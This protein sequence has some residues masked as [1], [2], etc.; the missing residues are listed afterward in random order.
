VVEGSDYFKC[1]SVITAVLLYFEQANRRQKTI[2]FAKI[3]TGS[4]S[5]K[6]KAGKPTPAQSG[7]RIEPLEDEEERQGRGGREEG[8][9]LW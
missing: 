3:P 5:S 2:K 4:S 9:G 7:K 1:P 8:G 6:H